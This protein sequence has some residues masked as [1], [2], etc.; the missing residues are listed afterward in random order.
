MDGTVQKKKSHQINQD[1]K[2]KEKVA[3]CR[4]EP[5]RAEL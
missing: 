1:E 3:N 2:M 5:W 4:F